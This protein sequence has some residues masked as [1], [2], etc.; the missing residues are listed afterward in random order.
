MF[1]SEHNG[2]VGDIRRMIE[3]TD[4][5]RTGALLTA[6]EETDWKST[7][8]YTARDAGYDYGERLFQAARFV[9]EM[10]YQ[11]LAFEEFIRKVQPMV[12]PF[13]EGGTGYNTSINPAIKAEFAHAVYRFGHSMLTE[14]VDRVR[15][16]GTR[17]DIDLF[18]AFVNPPEFMAGGRS[19][20]QASGDVVRGMTRQV[21]NEIDEFVTDALRNKLLGLPLD[22]ATLNMARARDTGIPT[23]NAARRSFFAASNNSAL[24]PYQ[25]WA[26]FAFVLKHPKSL[27]NFI[28]AYGTHPTITG[29]TTL[30]AKRDAADAIVY[31]PNGPDGEVGTPDDIADAP[32]D[33]Y[34]FLNSAPHQVTDE[35]TGETTVVN[36]TWVDPANTTNTG[37]DRID[38]WAGGLAEKQFVFG[39]LL[40]PTFNYVFEQQMEDLQFGDRFY[41]LTRTAGLNMLTQLEGNSFA[42]LIQRN[43][44]VS[45]LP[46]DSFSTP[47]LIF[48]VANLGGSGAVLND[49]GTAWN[50]S[51]LLTR[52]PDGTIRYGGP[53]H[54]V[55]NGTAGNNR[56]WSSEGDDTIRGNDGNDWVQGGDGNDNHIGG[57]G[58]DILLDTNGDDTIKGGDG[59]DVIS[60]G[61]GAGGDLN[62]GGRGNDFI[63]HDDMAESF[64]G[65]GDDYVLGGPE[66]D[67][68]FGD[69]GDDWL[70]TGASA[71]GIGGGAFNL[72]QGDN[73]APFQDDPNEPGHDVL[74]GYGG[75]SDNDAEGG[76]DV[77]LNGPGIQRNEGMLGFD[78]ATHDGDPAAA[79]SD[80]DLTGLLPPS[81]ET[82]KDRF[83]LVEA[84]SGWNQNDTLR[85]DDRDAVAM[86]GH[87]LTAAGTARVT[88]L[89]T[90]LGGA[91][92]FTGG[93]LLLGGGG[94]D[95]I[96]GRGG[97]DLIDG[98]AQLNVRISVRSG[99]AEPT[100]EI[101]TVETLSGVSARLIAGSVNP[102]QLRIVR[103]IETPANG[104]AL[105]TAIFSGPRADYD[106]TFGATATT[107]VHARGTALDGTDTLRNIERLR[108]AD[109]EIAN[110][111]P[112]NP[113]PAVTT[114]VPR[115]T[116][117]TR[118]SAPT[119]R[120]TSAKPSPESPPG[121]SS[122]GQ[123]ARRPTSPGP[124]PRAPPPASGS[125][126][127]RTTWR[128]A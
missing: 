87:E 5:A 79:D 127:P 71:T 74:I 7:T 20:D 108:F 67:T 109:Q 55:F 43:T 69:D 47:A 29:A 21:G 80:L 103:E 51:T 111:T 49:P 42:E 23:L 119:S 33:R 40:G 61:Q 66:D 18:D 84:L 54:V 32:E 122:S 120:P 110:T 101:D 65:A 9:T 27:N 91:T 26:D 95:L 96:E 59:N 19:P 14:S 99:V 30:V 36:T 2:L 41:Y 57:L 126:T 73:G 76:D 13:G 75:E 24:A 104:D 3:G 81:V 92:T 102:G 93:N 107:V 60:S 118:R 58:D 17:D 116:P 15:S 11:H 6:A 50:E 124:S 68:V 78:Y 128:Q 44:D 123:P 98:D 77:M 114:Q 105:D 113:A 90:V 86:E 34:A 117:S 82:N 62:Q 39:G 10:E 97:D 45:G 16:N 83:D 106:I 121:R 125:S 72:L 94:T 37:L 25:S 46:A 1:H 115:R 8:R 4:A 85:G 48:D 22:L 112:A 53:E 31:G 35:V 28:A 89:S 88:G 38:L 12:A 70:E 63:D 52:M 100:T 64:A 56:V